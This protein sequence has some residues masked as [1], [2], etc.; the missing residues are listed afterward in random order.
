MMTK[1]EKDLAQAEAKKAKKRKRL[2]IKKQ[3]KEAAVKDDRLFIAKHKLFTILSALLVL[4]IFFLFGAKIYLYMNFLLGND[5]ALSLD[6]DKKDFI[7][8][9]GDKESVNFE[10]KITANPFCRVSCTSIFKDISQNKDIDKESFEIGAATP[11]KKTYIV[12][13]KEAKIGLSL[14]R[15]DMECKGIRTTLCH[16]DETSASTRSILITVQ[17]NLNENELENKNKL[18]LQLD[19]FIDDINFIQTEH[20]IIENLILKLDVKLIVETFKV[21]SGAVKSKIFSVLSLL[22][23]AKQ[24]WN[25]QEYALLNEK[26][27]FI[28]N[29]LR[30]VQLVFSDLNESVS[31]I[32]DN[33]NGFID[34]FN[35]S[36]QILS[37]NKQKFFLND[38]LVN[39][40]N[41]KI[42]DFNTALT[43]F[44]ANTELTEKDN[45][46]LLNSIKTISTKVDDANR[47]NTLLIK[48]NVKEGYA[49]LCN[50]TGYCPIGESNST[51]LRAACDNVV[52]F[53]NEYLIKTGKA[54]AIDECV[55]SNVTIIDIAAINLSRIEADKIMPIEINI[56]FDEPV[57]QCCAFGKC[58]NCCIDCADENYPV[59]FLHGHAVNKDV[60]A[61]YSLEGFN[62]IQEKLEEEGYINAGT[63][64]LYTKLE[65]SKG[66]LG[67][68]NNPVSLRTSYYFDI[69]KNPENSVVVQTKSENID[70]YAVRLKELID[71]IKYETGKNKVKIVAYSMGGLVSRR[72]IQIFGSEDVDRLIMI[73]TPNK[74]IVGSILELCPLTGESLECKDMNSN[75][76]FINKLNTGI[77]PSIPVYNIVGS[78]CNMNGK[79]GDGAVLTENAKLD[80]TE[81]FIIN[82]KCR[83]ATMPLH[84]DL[85]NIKMYPEVYDILVK[86]IK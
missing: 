58:E 84:L 71:M 10:A 41:N 73:G 54:Y 8:S 38:S 37:D 57:P 39:E 79:D 82:G 62:E 11:F 14:Y 46:A 44:G 36:S 61:E 85:R 30:D 83:S 78:G 5:V 23:E 53:K 2:Y 56:A 47:N 59:V 65:S 18:N 70:T 21:N 49:V 6:A 3:K 50:E 25:D 27:S 68:L 32:V 51:D 75:S 4:V 7:L 22:E 52:A 15:L 31:L 66:I 63:I 16:T 29:E 34:N 64:T 9:H 28:E 48:S 19:S 33:Y 76:L 1:K 81:N 35:E 74:G 80:W 40:L 24:L 45:N 26:T 17:T 12:E 43:I 86:V 42:N 55:K 67:E 77:K 20:K 69:F 60:L 13:A 72:Y